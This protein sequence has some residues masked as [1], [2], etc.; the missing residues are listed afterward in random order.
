MEEILYDV[1]C[2]WNLKKV[3]LIKAGVNGCFQRAG[4]ERNG[5]M[6]VK[7]VQSISYAG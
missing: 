7:M 5:E 4:D 6:L 3:E 2:M 1:E